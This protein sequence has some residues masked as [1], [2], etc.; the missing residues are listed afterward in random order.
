M[1]YF[2][3]AGEASGDLHGSNL[4]YG[5]KSIDKETE[6][7]CWGGGKMEAAGGILDEHYRN[8]AFMGFAEVV[9][10]IFTIA[11]LFKKCKRNI[12]SFNP[13]VIVFIDYPGFNLRM[14]PWAKKKGF[15]CVYYITPQVWAWH[16]SRIH[17]LGSYADKLISILPFEP[18]F[19]KK[20]GYISHYVGHPLLDAIKNFTPDI[21]LTNTYRNRSKPIIALLPG[22]RE[23]EIREILP[24]ML[25]ALDFSAYTI[26]IAGTS[27]VSPDSYQK[28]LKARTEYQKAD[29]VFNQTYSILS[30][31]DI[32]LVGSGTATL[33][34]ALFNVPQIVC[35]KGNRLSFAIAKRLVNIPYIS[36]VNLIAEKKIVSELI[37]NDL[38][39]EGLKAEI[40]LLFTCRKQVLES[41]KALNLGNDGAS[42]RAAALIKEVCGYH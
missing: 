38:T 15:K 3:I 9:K 16:L 36:L 12:I 41:Y 25:E 40:S 30:I 35:Y 13:D 24:V 20:H 33:E 21:T 28:C 42:L 23:Q 18:D 6:V 11:K 22:S 2:I 31:A 4:I 5:L 10:N 27:A 1:K 26:V 34:T 19:F 8:T 7:R 37:Q 39:P 14:L 32:A 17:V 29:L